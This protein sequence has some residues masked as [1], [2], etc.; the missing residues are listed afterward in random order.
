MGGYPL[1][2]IPSAAE[3]SLWE[4]ILFMSSRAQPRDLYGNTVPCV[5]S[6][7]REDLPCLQRV[8]RARRNRRRMGVCPWQL[9]AESAS[10]SAADYRA[11]ASGEIFSKILRGFYTVCL[12][13][14]TAY[15][16]RAAGQRPVRLAAVPSRRL[17]QGDTNGT[18]CHPEPCEG[19]LYKYHPCVIPSA[20]EGS[21]PNSVRA[22]CS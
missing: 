20:A 2:V 8:K 22:V 12:A 3:G 15:N 13:T 21:E 7:A 5:I 16:P 4:V 10:F 9:V 1:Y 17:A 14:L 6:K 19:S 18:I 11:Q